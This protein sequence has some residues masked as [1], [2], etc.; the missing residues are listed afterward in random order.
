MGPRSL[1][2]SVRGA[3]TPLPASLD[4]RLAAAT[5]AASGKSPV[6]VGVATPRPKLLVPR[7]VMLRPAV[8]E[9]IVEIEV[10]TRRPRLL[11]PRMEGL[12]PTEVGTA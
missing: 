7:L 10:S 3:P 12:R 6:L 1:P 8:M 11:R 9:R 4:V 5:V 2:F